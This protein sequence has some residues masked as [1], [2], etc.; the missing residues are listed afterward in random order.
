M[1]FANPGPARRSR[2]ICH[3]VDTL[4][5]LCQHQLVLKAPHTISEDEWRYFG[6][7]QVAPH[8]ISD[9]AVLEARGRQKLNRRT[10]ETREPMIKDVQA[11]L[12]LD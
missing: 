2:V 3:T 12:E 11:R 9:W 5:V 7:E 4:N 10:G 1:L 8:S 6:S